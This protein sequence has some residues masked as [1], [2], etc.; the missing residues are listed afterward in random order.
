MIALILITFGVFLLLCLYN[1]IEADRPAAS[2]G[3]VIDPVADFVSKYHTWILLAC[4]FASFIFCAYKTTDLHDDDDQ[5]MPMPRNV[6]KSQ[7]GERR[8]RKITK[9]PPRPASM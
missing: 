1:M 3:P 6:W 7:R 8:K 2:Y 5:V 9:Q 4:F